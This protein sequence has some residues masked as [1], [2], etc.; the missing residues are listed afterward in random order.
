MTLE[1]AQN[2]ISEAFNSMLRTDYI[3]LNDVQKLGLLSTYYVDHFGLLPEILSDMDQLIVGRRGTGKTTLLYRALVGCMES[4]KAD[5]AD[6]ASPK[7]RTLGIY[8]DLSKCQYVDE[9][10]DTDFAAFEHAFVSEVCDAI[11]D[12]L[13][14]FWP[15]LS[16]QP[17]YFAKLFRAA[18]SNQIVEVRQVLERIG[19]V[20]K[21]G[22]PRVI[23]K[24]TSTQ[25]KEGTSVS[26]STSSELN[27]TVGP[28]A[29]VGA[30]AGENAQESQAVER[31]YAVGTS[32]RLTIAD[33]LRILSELR[34]KAG[35]SATYVL[36]DEFSAL[37][38]D[39]QRRFSTLLKKLLGSH[40][41]VFIKLCAITDKYTLGS[42]VILQRD[43]FEISLDLDAFVERSGTL[44]EAM[45]GLQGFSEDIVRSRLAAYGC[46]TPE[47][48]FDNPNEAWTS[49]SRSAMGVPRTLGIVL[50]Q[51]WTR[52]RQAK[53]T[54][55]IRKTDISYGVRYAST[56]YLNQLLGA[57][58]DGVAVPAF[59]ADLWSAL[60]ARAQHERTRV[61]DAAASHFL[62]LAR[63]ERMLTILNMFFLVHLLTK[64]RTTKKERSIRSLYC[65]DFGIC[66]ESNLGFTTDKNVIR[67]QR[68]A[69]D[70][71]LRPF[72][73]FFGIT[74]E[75]TF[76][77]PQCDSIYTEN[78][79]N[80][81]G[82]AISFCPRDKADLVRQGGVSGGPQ[83]TE[84]ETKIIGTI[85]SA[86]RSDHLL[87]RQVADDVG[88]YVQKVAKFGE[89]LEREGLA[90]RERDPNEGKLFYYDSE[91]S[92]GN[93]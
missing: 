75:A 4:W 69:Y 76:R 10:P 3:S 54:M 68:F 1:Y 13:T 71:V 57:A 22:V 12:Q 47:E 80:V 2:R 35:L 66:E 83:F 30:S 6:D 17:G 59:H 5:C 61:P 52:A 16:Q 70:D 87:A 77:C 53:S 51:A 48:V 25:I 19:K 58:R 7:P 40:A 37:S 65:F 93:S 82:I 81:A 79:L 84:E 90:T 33:I 67:Q 32:Y 21:E 27:A 50:K 23:D 8:V 34:E 64:G 89:K 41:G 42:S 46:P 18:E 55:K 36:I 74:A 15:A 9:I 91:K 62:I 45:D 88:C 56:A 14:R 60:S 78:E 29:S 72:E 49:L 26:I 73:R 43:L 11:S 92:S 86:K 39:L 20:L 85:R 24:S 38:T 44:N 31:S 28:D 63:N